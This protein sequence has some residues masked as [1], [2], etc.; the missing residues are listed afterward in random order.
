MRSLGG[1]LAATPPASQSTLPTT[2]RSWRRW[3]H[4]RTIRPM[5]PWKRCRRKGPFLPPTRQATSSRRPTGSTFVSAWRQDGS[6]IG[7]FAGPPL[8]NGPLRGGWSDDN[9]PGH[10]VRDVRVDAEN[11]VWI[12]LEFR[13]PDW[14]EGV[15]ERV[16][17]NG[18]V[19]LRLAD[20]PQQVYRFRVDVVD[21]RTCT[22]L[23]SQWLDHTD[24]F[25]EFVGG[26]DGVAVSELVHGEAGDPL[27][28]IWSMVLA[29]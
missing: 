16:M 1:F 24:T 5:D 25:G 9:P 27:V 7:R 22:A 28:N 17:S 23:A 8:G 19:Q 10:H 2:A 29:R 12:L 13:R 3:E 26:G 14:R 6:R 15:V 20:G 4:R 21:P 18:D 11:R